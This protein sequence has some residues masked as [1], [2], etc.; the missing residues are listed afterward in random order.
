MVFKIDT[1]EFYSIIT[2]IDRAADAK[3]AEKL[4][5]ECI[6]LGQRG[7][8]GYIIDM[9]NCSAIDD[10]T[11]GLLHNLHE[12]LYNS[13]NSLV[14]IN[15]DNALLSKFQNSESELIINIAPT[16]E[17]AIDIINMDRLERDILNGD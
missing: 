1:T 2:P 17:E 11:I 14:F 5:G 16:L 7:S 8:D 9:K 15:M 4:K 13:E 6:E 12:F 10:E 3:M